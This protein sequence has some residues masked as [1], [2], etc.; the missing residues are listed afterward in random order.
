MAKMKPTKPGTPRAG[1]PEAVPADYEQFLGGLRDRIRTTQLRASLAVNREL[2]TLNW[3][4]GKGLVER[5]KV[6][7]WGYAVINRLGRDLQDAFP[8]LAGFSRT[9]VYRMRAFYLAY[10]DLGEF[11]PQAVGQ[12]PNEGTPPFATE[13]VTG[14]R[15]LV[16]PRGPDAGP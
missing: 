12:N 15:E 2:I 6:H 1:R 9:N 3:H 13:R 5:Q 7:G 8:G 10:P 4:I 16:R 14:A 11:V